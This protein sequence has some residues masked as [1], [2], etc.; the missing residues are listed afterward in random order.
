[1]STVTKKAWPA[2]AVILVCSTPETVVINQRDSFHTAN[3]RD[4]HADLVYSGQSFARAQ[5]VAGG[6]RP[7]DF[8]CI[9]CCVT[10]DRNSIEHFEDHRR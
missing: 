6:F 7:V 2:D 9:D 10:Y 8:L 5:Q 1:M 4:C 3:C